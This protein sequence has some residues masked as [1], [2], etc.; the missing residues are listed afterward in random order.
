MKTFTFDA[1]A[2]LRSL[3][4]ADVL[5]PELRIDANGRYLR[6]LCLSFE[7]WCSSTPQQRREIFQALQA[8]VIAELSPQAAAATPAAPAVQP[9]SEHTADPIPQ[10]GSQI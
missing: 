3:E 2:F 5:P 8:E 9:Q 4:W 6:K 10:P 7:T 1:D